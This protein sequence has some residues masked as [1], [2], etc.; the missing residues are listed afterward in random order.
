MLEK[1]KQLILGN[2]YSIRER[3][4]RI[5]IAFSAVSATLGILECMLVMKMSSF[6][7][8]VL[9]L[10]LVIMLFSFYVAFRYRKYKLASVMIELLVVGI[11][12]PIM[13]FLS[14]GLE[15]GAT[16]WYA[17]GIVFTYIMFQGRARIGFVAFCVVSYAATYVLGY[18]FP[19]WVVVM[20]TPM[21]AYVD[22]FFAVIMVGSIGGII[23]NL[24]LEMFEKEH[25]ANMDKTRQLEESR[26]SKNSLLANMSH[27]IRTP[28]NAIIGLNEMILRS[29]PSDEI[30][31]YAGD[32]RIASKML[33]TQVND[34]LDLSRM[35]MDKMNIFPAKYDADSLFHE[36]IEFVRGECE[37]KNLELRLELDEKIPAVLV[38][39][40][41]R[42]K[43]VILNL[44]D[45]AVKYTNKGG[46]TM[47]IQGENI[48]DTEV[49]L[50]IIVSDTGI[51]IRKEDMAHLFD[52]FSRM[53]EKKNKHITGSGLGL[54]IVRQLLDLMGGEISV[55][56]IYTKGSVFTVKV[57]QGVSS[58][59]TIGA[60][61]IRE[62]G[63]SSNVY[64]PAFEAPEAR[65]LIVDDNR[66]NA[67]VATRL[68]GATKVQVEVAE[69]G[70]KCLEMTRKKYYHV[71]LMDYLMPGMDGTQTMQ[72]IRRQENGL[73]RESAIIAL[74]GNTSE[75]I[76][77]QCMAEGFDGYVE[78]P[79]QS[80]A[81][82]MEIL[83]FLSSDIVEYV[84]HEI[85]SGEGESG[86]QKIGIK[87]RKKIL[88]T[89]DCACDISREQLEE[90]GIELMYLYVR[91]PSG[92]FADTREIDMDSMSEWISVDH[93]DAFVESGT[94]EEY[95]EFFAEML[96]GA[97]FV[98]HIS[99]SAFTGKNYENAVAAAKGFN[100]VRVVDS[101]Q[102]SCGFALLVMQAAKMANA[103]C[104]PEVICDELERIK[105]T[106]QT[107]F[108]MPGAEIY[109]LRG[110][111]RELTFKACKFF[112]LHLFVKVMPEKMKVVG[113]LAGDLQQARKQG[114]A[115]HLRRKHKI[116]RD[117]V[118]VTH[119]GCT[120]EEQE[121]IKKEISKRIHFKQIIVQKASFTSAS[122]SGTK[123]LAISHFEE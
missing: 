107:R 41:K 6:L 32:I 120:L 65:V 96:S 17:I 63:L 31:E 25:A 106:I 97:E 18:L 23:I 66:M 36:M 95:E 89:A 26:D 105:Q 40:E 112:G 52:T 45:N 114:I 3:M 19:D 43:Q 93:S 81:L 86:L 11:I 10:L 122:F 12:F 113:L 102:V 76:R 98:I 100:H 8:P 14:G 4:I 82:E 88:I 5:I 20:P 87:K 103:N 77:E 60:I 73:C 54:S 46:V 44:L 39:D 90:L 119:V 69:T 62:R 123:S 121:W 24:S 2:D 115:W 74:T 117:I 28:I 13:F 35:E 84:E 71:I 118:V 21:S 67:L 79:I 47:T 56:S 9:G 15:G 51:G 61:S 53:D 111:T 42:L 16:V 64:K 58:K 1:I 70:E 48:S 109:Y 85:V 94:V 80:R 110:Q 99:L 83:Q 92:R 22:S 78:K 30:A 75:G 49:M 104:E 55:D 38:G 108:I 101:A 33:L 37:K 116:N 59:L 27:E 72:T 91:T 34:V 29:N 7:I 50:T 57:K 68:L